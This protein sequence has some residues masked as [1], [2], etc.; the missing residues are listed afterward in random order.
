MGFV[1][2]FDHVSTEQGSAKGPAPTINSTR[3]LQPNPSSTPPEPS[4]T[5]SQKH[6]STVFRRRQWLVWKVG[7]LLIQHALY[8][9]LLAVALAVSLHNNG[10][11]TI[12]NWQ[13]VHT[14]NSSF[15][16]Q[17]SLT[18]TT[19]PTL[20]FSLLLLHMRWCYEEI[21]RLL[22]YLQLYK[23]RDKGH[24]SVLVNYRS[25]FPL[26]AIF[27]AWMRSHRM[28]SFTITLS[29]IF[30]IVAVPLSSH[31][32]ET[33]LRQQPT[34]AEVSAQTVWNSGNINERTDYSRALQVASVLDVYKSN[35]GI[36][37]QW[38]S[39][40]YAFPTYSAVG[41]PWGD[42]STIR[43]TDIQGHGGRIEGLKFLNQ[44]QYRL[45]R[46]N[47]TDNIALSGTDDGCLLSLSF[48]LAEKEVDL[49]FQVGVASCTRNGG[50]DN[51]DLGPSVSQSYSKL[52]FFLGW[53]APG[54]NATAM[55]TEV[56]TGNTIHIGVKGDIEVAVRENVVS[57]KSFKPSNE[58][59]TNAGTTTPFDRA[60][61]Q[62]GNTKSTFSN[63]QTTYFGG[64]ILDRFDVARRNASTPWVSVDASTAEALRKDMMDAI[65]K[66]YT[67]VYVS[68]AALNGFEPVEWPLDYLSTGV[69]IVR[70][71]ERLFINE[72]IAGFLIGVIIISFL[73]AGRALSYALA[74]RN[75]Q[76]DCPEDLISSFDLL[77]GCDSLGHMAD[78]VHSSGQYKGDFVETARKRWNL[79]KATFSISRDESSGRPTLQVENLNPII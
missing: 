25:E 17:I 76:V 73:I 2:E 52:F 31:L 55:S 37:S 15:Y 39:S 49:Y 51:K 74:F 14:G 71:V 5:K 69:Y 47:G 63:I 38:A 62:S 27:S 4:L 23:S 79:S 48:D 30:S 66:I 57:V 41:T 6:I 35:G 75:Y 21:Q 59:E 64:L 13:Y 10:L 45:S 33:R 44:S 61:L 68:A 58:S 70:D 53:P 65:S 36:F 78:D 11:A 18:W 43:I 67:T 34:E 20:I 16:D 56:I 8:L 72:G 40:D 24:T 9:I 54:S 60:I 29:L 50:D 19:I 12:R 7:G 28:V 46:G 32:F 77:H 22:P 42:N 1:E 26:I 3:P